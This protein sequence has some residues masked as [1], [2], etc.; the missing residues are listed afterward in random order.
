MRPGDHPVVPSTNRVNGRSAL[1][2]A[3]RFLVAAP[4]S[5]PLQ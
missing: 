4:F 1:S 3:G 5:P 2:V